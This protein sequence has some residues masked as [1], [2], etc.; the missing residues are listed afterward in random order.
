MPRATKTSEFIGVTYDRSRRQWLAQIR[1]HYNEY[2]YIQ[3]GPYPSYLKLK[4]QV[5]NL[6]RFAREVDA[7]TAYDEFVDRTYKG[8]RDTN[9]SLGLLD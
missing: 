1:V 6:G 7:A 2:G 8:T 4:T 3:V 5:L 9:R